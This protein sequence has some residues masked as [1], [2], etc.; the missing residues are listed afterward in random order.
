MPQSLT[1]L[2]R[3]FRSGFLN[4]R[5]DRS[6]LTGDRVPARHSNGRRW[7]LYIFSAQVSEM[8]LNVESGVQTLYYG[9]GIIFMLGGAGGGLH[10]GTARPHQQARKSAKR[11]SGVRGRALSK[12]KRTLPSDPRPWSTH[13]SRSPSRPALTSEL[14]SLWVICGKSSQRWNSFAPP[15]LARRRQIRRRQVRDSTCACL[16]EAMLYQVMP[17][18][19]VNTRCAARN[20]PQR[21]A[22]LNRERCFSSCQKTGRNLQFNNRTPLPQLPMKLCSKSPLI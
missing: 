13:R 17:R 16:R 8:G 12:L 4:V 15:R 7:R 22:R 19:A 9:L 21:P 2:L 18:N 14:S 1:A 6:P 10:Q 3:S 11:V 5:I 20:W